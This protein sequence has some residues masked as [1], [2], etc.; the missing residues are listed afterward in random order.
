MRMLGIKALPSARAASAL[1]HW[2]T[3]LAP[4]YSLSKWWL[5][6]GILV[7][8]SLIW[9]FSYT[10]GRVIVLSSSYKTYLCPTVPGNE[11][12]KDT[13]DYTERDDSRQNNSRNP[14]SPAF[15]LDV[16]LEC[17]GGLDPAGQC[18]KPKGQGC[19][20]I[21][22]FFIVRELGNR[23]AMR[24]LILKL[25]RRMKS[26]AERWGKN[27]S[28]VRPESLEKLF[29]LTLW[30]DSQMVKIYRGGTETVFPE[31]KNIC[32]ENPAR[33]RDLFPE[34]VCQNKLLRKGKEKAGDYMKREI[35]SFYGL[36]PQ[37]QRPSWGNE[38]WDAA[39]RLLR[40]ASSGTGRFDGHTV[41]PLG[42]IGL[43][44]E[45]NLLGVDRNSLGPVFL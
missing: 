14:D 7:W 10:P 9:Q 38:A 24:R 19:P 1:D 4:G 37:T 2:A 40:I 35:S 42:T 34:F 45:F 28:T 25:C 33:G 15:I 11:L 13:Q 3:S 31:L 39:V 8:R 30:V 22:D 17:Q 21:M 27:F 26:I 16:D 29:P 41:I 6:Y 44:L 36:T 43:S 20:H 18:A 32:L 5:H 12:S 23:E